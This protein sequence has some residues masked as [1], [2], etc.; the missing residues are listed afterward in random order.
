MLN[1]N[2]NL[3]RKRQT[4][5]TKPIAK[6]TTTNTT[7]APAKNP[8]RVILSGKSMYAMVKTP[9]PGYKGGPAKWR[10][11]LLLSPSEIAK[12]RKVGARVRGAGG[13]PSQ[14]AQF[15]KYRD[16]CK[17]Q[18]WD[19]L[20]YTGEFVRFEQAT[21]RKTT[22]GVK[23]YNPPK[24]YDGVGDEILD[25]LKIGNGSDIRVTGSLR[26]GS[27]EDP[28]VFGAYS[29][30]LGYIVVNTLVEYDVAKKDAFSY[31]KYKDGDKTGVVKE[32]VSPATSAPF[33]SADQ[34]DEFDPS[35]LEE[36]DE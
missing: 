2:P 3:I 9:N 27:P 8:D 12:A 18:G 13:T 22:E 21:E 19:A 11:D 29:L 32:S 23:Q 14:N 4:M 35:M 31:K 28:M 5:A 10:V 17:E 20:G 33:A 6:K 15:E 24:L 7:A 25:D 16:F 30:S 34:D 26:K 36:D 1:Y